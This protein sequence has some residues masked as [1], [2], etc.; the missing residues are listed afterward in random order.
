ME[1]PPR[2][3]TAWTNPRPEDLTL[4]EGAAHVWLAALPD[5]RARTA[6]AGGILSP[7]E[8]E[9]AARFIRPEDRDRF[10]TGRSI[11]RMILGRYTGR[12][13]ESLEFSYSPHGKP[14]LRHRTDLRFNL[15]DSRM[16]VLVAVACKQE[17]GIDIEHSRSNVAAMEIAGRFF[18]PAE[19]AALRAI[20]PDGRIQAFFR[21]WTRKEAYLKA[22]GE[23]LSLPLSRFS[24]SFAPGA[25]AALLHSED[26]PGEPGRWSLR[27]I[28]IP[29]YC[30]ALAVAGPCSSLRYWRWTH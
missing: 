2:E 29:D 25:P 10:I 7:D 22:R 1:A 12:A 4:H 23:G 9:R 17:V 5:E 18:S 21:C 30:A 11:L 20:P 14:A 8:L 6:G 13:P 26:D 27:D 19:I 3:A 28:P 15:S 24:V 16:L